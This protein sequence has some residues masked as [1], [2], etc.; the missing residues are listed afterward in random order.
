MRRSE[1]DTFMQATLLR[2]Q[3]LTTTMGIAFVWAC[4]AAPLGLLN[5]VPIGPTQSL[6]NTLLLVSSGLLWP[7]VVRRPHTFERAGAVFFAV[8][9]YVAIAAQFLS[10]NDYFRPMLFFPCVGAVFLIFGAAAGWTALAVALGGFGLAVAHGNLPANPLG[11]STFVLALSVTAFLF[12]LFRYQALAA[13][14]MIEA[15]NAA[16]DKTSREDPLTGLL[17]LR[18]FR[19]VMA[20]WQNGDAPFAIAFLDIDHFKSINDQYGHDGGD[21]LLV[22]F[23]RRLSEMRRPQDVIAR[24]GGEEFAVLMPCLDMAEAEALA[25]RLRSAIATA[26]MELDGDALTITASIGVA[27]GHA[28]P[29]T[30]PLKIA[31]SAMYLAKRCGRNRV[32]IAGEQPTEAP[33]SP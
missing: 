12:H 23:A 16:L 3:V 31:D 7:L 27:M 4:F 25:E 11:T 2:R 9:F 14:E 20:R 33:A 6:N 29:G 28:V 8:V 17:N 13:L 26:S 5:L 15:Q 24:I 21:T 19:D 22:A 10:V 30:S 1:H 32:V 18:A